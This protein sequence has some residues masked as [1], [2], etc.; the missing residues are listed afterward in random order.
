MCCISLLLFVIT[1]LHINSSHPLLHSRVPHCA[2]PQGYLTSIHL[3]PQAYQILTNTSHSIMLLAPTA[4]QHITGDKPPSP[5]L[6]TALL[7]LRTGTITRDLLPSLRRWCVHKTFQWSASYPIQAPPTFLT[8]TS[9]T[10]EGVWRE[11]RLL[12]ANFLVI[13]I[14][15][16][17]PLLWTIFIS[18]GWNILVRSTHPPGLTGTLADSHLPVTWWVLLIPLRWEARTPHRTCIATATVTGRRPRRYLPH[19]RLIRLLPLLLLPILRW[20]ACNL[21]LHP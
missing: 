15:E 21:Y 3:T 5:P 2:V 14:P 6:P 4:C 10:W 13:P 16:L 8:R 18:V 20:W 12:I 7:S 1:N 17:R 9:M 19:H 11:V